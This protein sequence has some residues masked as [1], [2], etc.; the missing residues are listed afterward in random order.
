MNRELAKELSVIKDRINNIE[1]MLDMQ[2]HNMHKESTD[3]IS[4]TDSTV[5]DLEIGSAESESAIVDLEIAVAELK[6]QI[7]G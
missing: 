2:S 1:R 3:S 7:G 5:V 6:Q 4:E